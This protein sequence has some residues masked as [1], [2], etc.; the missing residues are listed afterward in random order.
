M[1][2]FMDTLLGEKLRKMAVLS[3]AMAW[4]ESFTPA[5]KKDILSWI[6]DDQL[7]KRGVDEDEEV[8]GYYSLYTEILSG[9][10]KKFGEHYTLEDTGEFFKSM[11]IVVLSDS[12]VIEA[13][14]IK[15]DDNL[16]YK[17]GDGIIG[18]TEENLEFFQLELADKYREYARKTLQID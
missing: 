9:G 3:D 2:D 11:Y 8:I 1:I 16:F 7:R 10:R 13:D 17:Y 6:Q 15:G 12:I 18:L 14:P 4:Y 5:F